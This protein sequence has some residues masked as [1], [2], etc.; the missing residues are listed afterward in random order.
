MAGSAAV[1][2]RVARGTSA[3]FGQRRGRAPRRGWLRC[4]SKVCSQPFPSFPSTGCV[5]SPFSVGTRIKAGEAHVSV[6]MGGGTGIGVLPPPGWLLATIA[7]SYVVVIAWFAAR[8]LWR[9]IEP[10]CA[11][12]RSRARAPYGGSRAFLGAL[13]E[14]ASAGVSIA[15]SSRIFSPVTMGLRRKLILLP[16]S[17]GEH[18][19]AADLHTVIAH[20]FAHIRAKRFPEKPVVP[21]ALPAS[22][23][24][25]GALAYASADH[26]ESRNG[27]R[28]D[29]HGH[30]GTK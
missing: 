11:A 19:P 5:R 17:M 21:G 1:C 12:A 6:V 27:L 16:A 8:F 3:P 10:F 28:P 30:D 2:R 13:L 24:P 22:D 29:G 7:I 25:S 15:A 23:L 26:G 18:L 4:C 9:A 14:K 20:E